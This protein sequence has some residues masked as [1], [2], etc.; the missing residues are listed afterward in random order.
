METLSKQ[1]TIDAINEKAAREIPFFFLISFSGE[2][3]LL[4]G[5]E[6]AA[7]AGIF[8]DMPGLKSHRL[9]KL[10]PGKYSGS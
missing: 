4:C 1:Q 10:L 2:E 7:S 8:L 5:P 3:S 9:E 6:E